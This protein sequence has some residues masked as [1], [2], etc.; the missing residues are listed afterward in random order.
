M[1]KTKKHQHIRLHFKF[2]CMHDTTVIVNCK[3]SVMSHC[4]AE[5]TNMVITGSYLT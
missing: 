4:D 5:H 3:G 1:N 2:H